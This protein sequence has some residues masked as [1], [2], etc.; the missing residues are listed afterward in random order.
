MSPEFF[1]TILIVASSPGVNSLT[2]TTAAENE[3]AP[4]RYFVAAETGAAIRAL[5][6]SRVKN[7]ITVPEDPEKPL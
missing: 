4:P 6:V 5:H 3:G 1:T 7:I 2:P